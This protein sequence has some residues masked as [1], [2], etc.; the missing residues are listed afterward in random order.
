MFVGYNT[1]MHQLLEW[2]PL[3]VF[4]VVF[5]MYG[6]YYGTAALMIGCVALMFVHRAVY[7]KYKTLH[8][9][10]AAVALILGAAT[11]LLHDKRFIQWKPTVLLGAASILFMGSAF[12]DRRPLARRMLENA[13]SEELG[14]APRAWTVINALWAAW[15]ALLAVLNIYI[16]HH[17]ADGVWVN[18]KVFGLTAG[19]ML[20]VIPQMLWLA[21]RTKPAAD[22]A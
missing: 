9:V 22:R 10:T 18:F 14:V 4:F 20:F 12:F 5:K 16:A 15:F 21:G 8:V 7:G 2:L 19:T 17:Y 3:L 1:P 11:L 6:I 13:F